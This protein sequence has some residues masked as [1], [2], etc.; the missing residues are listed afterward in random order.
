M[1]RREI[2]RFLR[3]YKRATA[4]GQQEFSTYCSYGIK[5]RGRKGAK[6]RS[7]ELIE[8]ERALRARWFESGA[9]LAEG[10]FGGL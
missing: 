6:R 3:S 9:A 8:V 1:E 7:E 4:T 10:C 5:S 2:A